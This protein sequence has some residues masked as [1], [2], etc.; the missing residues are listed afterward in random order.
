MARI[1][2]GDTIRVQAS[3]NIYT[4]LLAL[5][6]VAVGLGLLVLFVRASTLGVQLFK[7]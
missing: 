1:S 3:N 2:G 5:A 6:N 4:V 7:F